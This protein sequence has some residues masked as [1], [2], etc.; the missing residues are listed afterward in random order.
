MKARSGVAIVVLLV[1]CGGK[2][3][4]GSD[5][6]SAPAGATPAGSGSASSEPAGQPPAGS[7]A[8]VPAWKLES[9]P[10]AL[11]CG[12]RPLSIPAAASP[13]PASERALPRAQPIA[14]CQDQPSVEAVCSCLTGSV[15]KWVTGTGLTAPVSCAPVPQ[16][17][18]AARLVELHTTPS[19][20][21]SVAAG[22][23]FVLVAAHGPAWS[24]V[25]VVEAAPD[26]DLT[27][28]PRASHGAS[29]TSFEARPRPGATLVWI[30][31]Q[32]QYSETDMGEQQLTGAAQITICI[33]PTAAAQ[34]PYCHAPIKLGGWDYTFTI[35]K[36]DR[37]DACTLREAAVLSASLDSA[38]S[39]SVHLDRG[40]DKTAAAG[41]YHL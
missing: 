9:R 18:P 22:T 38:G 16:L 41:R 40:T 6:R 28:T 24:A 23:A 12:S 5:D 30:Q 34:A 10:V 8:A 32:N 33:V 17:D 29:I 2:K 36:A 7:A 21:D 39:L 14:A 15:E 19:D 26:V 4:A 1:A 37:P 31:S 20:P 13:A 11:M 27:T 35:A 3:T 25:G